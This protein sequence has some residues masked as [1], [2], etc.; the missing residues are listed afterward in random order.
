MRTCGLAIFREQLGRTDSSNSSKMFVNTIWRSSFRNRFR[1]QF[2]SLISFVTLLLLCS[3]GKRLFVLID[4]LRS[5]CDVCL[6]GVAVVFSMIEIL[7]RKPGD[8][9]QKLACVFSTNFDTKSF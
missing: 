8:V 2:F 3:V 6:F 4:S 1:L 7:P 9:T 5:F